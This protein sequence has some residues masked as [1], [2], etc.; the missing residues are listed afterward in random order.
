[1]KQ[2]TWNQREEKNS[3]LCISNELFL[4]LKSI[5][6]SKYGFHSTRSPNIL[7]LDIWLYCCNDS[8]QTVDPWVD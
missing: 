6:G 1:M 7:E 4:F 3:T 8:G 2:E 5:K